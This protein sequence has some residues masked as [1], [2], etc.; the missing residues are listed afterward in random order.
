[1]RTLIM[2]LLLLCP[3]TDSIAQ[4]RALKVGDKLPVIP[5][6]ERPAKKLL[7]L[8]F[9]GTGCKS[10]IEAFPAM[11]KL[12]EEFAE[13]MKILLVNDE[14]VDSTERFFKRRKLRKPNL[15]ILSGL[16]TFDILFPRNYVP[17]HVWIDSEGIVRYITDGYN[18]TPQNVGE[19][20]AG[21]PVAM[22]QLQ[23]G[24]PV[25][26]AVE[27]NY[28]FYSKLLRHIPGYSVGHHNSKFG[29]GKFRFSTSAGRLELLK[30]AFREQERYDFRA[31]N[32]V[33]LEVADTARYYF[34]SDKAA[35][36]S[37]LTANGFSYDLV[38]PENWKDER[39]LIAQQEICR[40]L[41]VRAFVEKRKV[42]CYMLIRTQHVPLIELSM[43]EKI[44]LDDP[45]PSIKAYEGNLVKHLASKLGHLFSIQQIPE[46]VIDGT[47]YTGV[48]NFKIPFKL[49]SP[50]N[51]PALRQHFQS[52][53]LDLVKTEAYT[54]VLVVREINK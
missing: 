46:P 20:L 25:E 50:L 27:D 49:M 1:M 30:F 33:Q 54:D 22:Q 34:P 48:L 39:Y 7:L 28:I 17:W 43:K 51:L 47:G 45:N 53:G 32:T 31:K 9:W 36:N 11:E 40:G 14:S 15:P 16:A 41:N 21:K 8:D 10:C 29:D 44:L 13:E 3:F 6:F 35:W 5:G 38:I 42:S 19:F 4:M 26:T 12:Q 23:Y 2:G 52:F 18:A 37:W 24:E